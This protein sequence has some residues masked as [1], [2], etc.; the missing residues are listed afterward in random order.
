HSCLCQAL[1]N[2]H[3]RGTILPVPD[4]PY[5][6]TFFFFSSR[7]RHTRFSRD[8]S[9]DVCSSD[10]CG[11]MLAATSR[12]TRRAGYTPI[13]RCNGR[14][15]GVDCPG[16]SI[17]RHLLDGAVER[18]FLENWGGQAETRAVRAQDTTDADLAAVDEDIEDARFVLT[19]S[20]REARALA[21]RRLEKLEDRRDE[22]L[23]QIGRAHV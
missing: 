19:S 18:V 6:R 12:G 8:W 21:L 23:S 3:S 13:Y 16:V 11:S 7:R 2:H 14:T 17:A 10:L 15:Q 4:S 5:T 9:S 20:D 22:L 1:R